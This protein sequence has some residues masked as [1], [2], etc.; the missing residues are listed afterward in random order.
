[1]DPGA[2]RAVNAGVDE[3]GE[4]T[5]RRHLRWGWTMLRA[6]EWRRGDFVGSEVCG[7][8]LGIVGRNGAVLRIDTTP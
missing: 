1:M 7:K 4:A 3:A 2:A 6:G 5:A 8:I